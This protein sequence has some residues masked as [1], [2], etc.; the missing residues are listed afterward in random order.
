MSSSVGEIVV[1]L[2]WTSRPLIARAAKYVHTLC[3]LSPVHAQYIDC[4]S[5]VI[6]RTVSPPHY[7]PAPPPVL[8]PL[9][10][11]HHVWQLYRRSIRGRGG[12]SS[13]SRRYP[14]T[15]RDVS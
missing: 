15:R 12:S 6:V 5:E 10:T 4:L 8:L 9:D 1:P 11:A 14:G 2:Q 13:G 3:V 7:Q